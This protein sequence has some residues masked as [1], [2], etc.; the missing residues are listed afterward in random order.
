MFN[1]HAKERELGYETLETVTDY[2]YSE[3]VV[4]A[5]PNHENEI[6][7][8]ISTRWAAFGRNSDILNS[9]LPLSL[10]KLVYNQR[11]L[12]VMTYGAETWG[13]TKRFE[14]KLRLAQQAMERTMLGVVL[15]DENTAA[16]IREQTRVEDILAQIKLSKWAW[17]P[18]VMLVRDN[19]WTIIRLTH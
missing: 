10:K 5:D 9:K 2:V 4:S 14:R 11:V 16:W 8:R 13:L 12:P 7:R 18:H 15:R 1:K 3:P 19:R 6:T 17:A